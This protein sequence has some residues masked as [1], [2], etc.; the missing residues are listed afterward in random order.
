MLIAS[1]IQRPSAPIDFGDKVYY[2]K[3][4]DQHDPKSEHVAVVTNKQH[5][6]RLLTIAEC[7]YIPDNQELQEDLGV[8]LVVAARPAAPAPVAPSGAELAL[9]GAV[10]QVSDQAGVSA[11][12][13]GV[14]A[15]VTPPGLTAAAPTTA[16]A[17]PDG[18][19]S[20]TVDPPAPSDSTVVLQELDEEA[21][22]A[23]RRLNELSWQA[24]RGQL[25]KGGIPREVLAEAL[26]LEELKPAEDQRA[27][28]VKLLKAKLG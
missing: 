12:V 11:A 22:E 3:P 15:A 25:D 18:T 9:I 14:A 17:P 16:T 26:R 23:G 2:F 20:S 24:L 10:D 7:Y 6:Q 4:R 27:T 28:T 19:T 21:R 1:R 5:I 8:Q 13:L